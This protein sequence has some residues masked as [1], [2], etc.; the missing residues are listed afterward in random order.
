MSHH[1]KV[2]VSLGFQ[3]GNLGFQL[4]KSGAPLCLNLLEGG[5]VLIMSMGNL[6]WE[7]VLFGVCSMFCISANFVV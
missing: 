2:S 4:M 5:G 6:A 3:P 7:G 1:V